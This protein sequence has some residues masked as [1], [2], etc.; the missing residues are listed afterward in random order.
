MA[1]KFQL[2]FNTPVETALEKARSAVENQHGIFNGDT[3]SGN[4]ELT[5][6]GN[7]IKGNYSIDGQVLYLEVTDKPLFVP[8]AMIEGFLRKE[9]S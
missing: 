9:I 7:F 8:C 2:S 3:T 4:F 5:V 6:F 1:C